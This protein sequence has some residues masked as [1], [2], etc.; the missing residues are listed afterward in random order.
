MLDLMCRQRSGPERFPC[1]S[2]AAPISVD[3]FSKI[4][5]Q[6]AIS[7]SCLQHRRPERCLRLS[8]LEGHSLEDRSLSQPPRFEC[9]NC[10]RLPQ[11][12]GQEPSKQCAISLFEYWPKRQIEQ[13]GQAYEIVYRGAWEAG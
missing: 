4:E 5:F 10:R 9:M 3:T 12:E 11:T 1:W 6:F 8:P 13:D 7:E 2:T